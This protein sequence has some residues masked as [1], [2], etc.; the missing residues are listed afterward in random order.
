MPA[1]M[2]LMQR[3]VSVLLVE[4]MEQPKEYGVEFAISIAWE[5]EVA[6][7]RRAMGAKSSVWAIFISGVM[8]ESKVGGK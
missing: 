1:L 6:G 3:S 4:K 2:P 5:R 7:K 8:E